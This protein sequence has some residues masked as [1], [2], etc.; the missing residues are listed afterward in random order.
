MLSAAKPAATILRCKNLASLAKDE[1]SKPEQFPPMAR[2]LA[3]SSQVARGNVGLSIIVPALQALGHEVIALPTVLLSNHPGHAHSAGTRVDPAVLHKML[4]A[5]DA[6]GWLTD[7]DGVLTGYLPTQEHVLFALACLRRVRTARGR[8]PMTYLCDPVLGDDPKGLYIDERA[9]RAIREHLVGLADIATPNRFELSYL[10]SARGPVEVRS[11]LDAFKRHLGCAM[12]IATSIPS[13][14]AGTVTNASYC[15]G[16]AEL[17]RVNLRQDAPHGTGDLFAALVLSSCLTRN[18][19]NGAL[20]FATAGVD[21]T[22]AGSA[23]H[24]Q[25]LV[26]ALPTKINRPAPW[27]VEAL[28]HGTAS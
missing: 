10:N 23:G 1:N 24:D 5:L 20:A 7:V 3:I 15:D 13:A 22:L 11:A 19:R 6:N 12:T 8:N 2:I 14:D 26:S 16:K 27:L 25:L 21:M 4:D 9:A 28:A 18:D 17:T